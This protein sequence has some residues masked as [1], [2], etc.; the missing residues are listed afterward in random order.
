MD[1]TCYAEATVRLPETAWCYDPLVDSPSLPVNALP[2][3][4]NGVVTFG[5][6]NRS[7]KINPAVV[8]AWAQILHTVPN[9]RL[10]IL[11]VAG[12]ARQRLLD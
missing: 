9:S 8:A 7:N 5:S 1:E 12:S 3:L 4:S 6:L 2:A 11:A 10:H